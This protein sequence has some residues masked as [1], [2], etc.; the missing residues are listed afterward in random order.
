ME[1]DIMAANDNKFLCRRMKELREENNL[2]MEEMAKRLNKANKSSISRA[3]S[4][5]MSYSALKDLAKEYCETF[6]MD[7]VQTEQFLRGDKIVIPDTSALLN[8][9][10][11][12][13]ELSK[14][15]SKVVIPK[16]VIDELDNIKNRNSGS[17]GKK[18][19]EIIKEIGSNTITI[20]REY[21]GDVAEKNNDCKIIYIAREVSNEFGCEVDIITN[22]ADYSAYL[23]GDKTVRALHLKEYRATKQNIFNLIKIEEIDKYYAETYDECPIPT[24]EEANAYFNNGYCDGY[25][26]IISTVRSNHTL[27]ERKAKIKWLISHGADVN[28]RDCNR[29][30]FPPL[31]HAIQMGDYGMFIFLLKEC[32]ANP[33]VGS[34]NPNRVRKVYQKNEETNEETNDDKNEGNMPL[35]IA[36]WDGKELF[37]RALCG[38]PRTS[39]NQQDANGFT[40]LIKACGNGFSKCRDILI[41]AGADTKIVDL[42]GKN[43]MDHWNECLEFGPLRTR[44][45]DKR[46]R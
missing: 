33:N 27:K 8:N 34:R 26:L 42:N 41:E 1:V 6:K 36:A 45:R 14:E 21:T 35:M 24:K 5:K 7:E 23:K 29:R 39:I 16:I 19:W 11:L 15:Y 30:Y 32:Q 3:E 37:V 20:Q 25:T 38:D 13:A 43:Y 9:T 4:G 10:Q 28:K 17:R 18:A 44:G 40:A 46:H 31:S 2:T 22:D 12:I